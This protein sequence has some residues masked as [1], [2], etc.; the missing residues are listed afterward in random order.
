MTMKKERFCVPLAHGFHM[1]NRDVSKYEYIQNEQ[2]WCSKQIPK[3]IMK[4]SH[5]I[6]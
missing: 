5:I 1:K 4:R 3:T 2:I 6:H